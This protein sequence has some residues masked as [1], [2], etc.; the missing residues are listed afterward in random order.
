MSLALDRRFHNAVT[1]EKGK[2]YVGN[3]IG[4]KHRNQK[5]HRHS[6]SMHTGK[7]PTDYGQQ[8]S[9]TK[10]LADPMNYKHDTLGLGVGVS[11]TYK[12]RWYDSGIF[13]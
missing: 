11:S 9:Y 6:V 1:G 12:P 4:Q 5:S 2:L 7:I 13:S 10:H 3:R 8:L